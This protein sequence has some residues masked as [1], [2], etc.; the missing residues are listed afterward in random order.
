MWCSGVYVDIFPFVIFVDYII[1]VVCAV[2]YVLLLS[3]C[4]VMWKFYK[5]VLVINYSILLLL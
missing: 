4:N 1:T 3:I 5:I 2:T